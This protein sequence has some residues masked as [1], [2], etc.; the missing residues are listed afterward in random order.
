MLLDMLAFLLSF[1]C[2]SIS[3]SLSL[4]TQLQS[5]FRAILLLLYI[6]TLPFLFPSLHLPTPKSVFIYAYGIDILVRTHPT[7]QYVR[8]VHTVGIRPRPS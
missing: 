4:F 6:T 1:S 8:A 3:P 7:M 5:S 2:H